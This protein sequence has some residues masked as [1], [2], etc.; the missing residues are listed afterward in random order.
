MMSEQVTQPDFDAIVIGAG[1]TGM[2]QTWLI[3]RMGLK[4]KGYEAGTD[5][6]GTW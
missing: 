6:G 1:L 4:V 2:Y 5:V 3:D